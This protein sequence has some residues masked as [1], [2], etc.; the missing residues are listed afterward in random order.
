MASYEDMHDNV[1]YKDSF[2][3]SGIKRNT[4]GQ[5]Q[6]DLFERSFS[7]ERLGS[8]PQPLMKMY[9]F[10]NETDRDVDNCVYALKRY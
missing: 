3:S 6:S 1:V 5:L 9:E 2:H 10:K 7:L 4:F 8:I